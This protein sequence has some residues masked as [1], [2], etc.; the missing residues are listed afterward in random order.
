MTDPDVTVVVCT[1]DRASALADALADLVAQELP[2]ASGS[3]EIV[4]VDDGS[5]D[6]T[7]S[8]IRSASQAAAITVRG[9]DGGGAGVAHARNVGVGASRGEWVAFF[10]DDQRTGPTWL[11]ELLTVARRSG[12]S[13]VG[14]PIDVVLPDGVLVGP[15]VRAVYGEHPTDR[16]R[17]RGEI[18]R[19]AGGNRLIDRRVFD[20]IGLHDEQLVVG[21]DLDLILRAEAAHFAFAWS[22]EARV[23]HLIPPERTEATAVLA[24]ART[25]G[26]ARA[27]VEG[28]LDGRWRMVGHASVVLAKAV[29]NMAVLAVAFASRSPVSLLDG[30]TRAALFR[31]YLATAFR[32]VLTGVVASR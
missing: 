30:R 23:R 7:A 10:D 21:E 12:A 2:A 18:P 4:V 24:Y 13:V 19:P 14:G 5:R 6:T 31:G 20:L 17:R 3:F 32:I 8:V 27:R 22:P 26:I 15:V 11:A 25:A 29:A 16:Q 28:K 9:V 1:R